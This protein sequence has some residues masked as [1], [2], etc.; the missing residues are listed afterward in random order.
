MSS[1]QVLFSNDPKKSLWWPLFTKYD[2]GTFRIFATSTKLIEQLQV[3]QDRACTIRL[4]LF[5]GFEQDWTGFIRI[6]HD[7]FGAKWSLT[8]G[9][10][11]KDKMAGNSLSFM[12]RSNLVFFFQR[13]YRAKLKDLVI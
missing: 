4:S 11:C 9:F 1:V 7:G 12:N 5:A 10:H 2:V 3:E 8:H 6:E 13:F